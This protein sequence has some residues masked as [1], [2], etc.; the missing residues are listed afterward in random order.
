MSRGLDR[1]DG[2]VVHDMLRCKSDEGGRFDVGIED[3]KHR[4]L[5]TYRSNS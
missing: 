2:D 5:L 3:S 4:P 1:G